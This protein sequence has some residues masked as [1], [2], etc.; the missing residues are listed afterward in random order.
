MSILFNSNIEIESVDLK[1]LVEKLVKLEQKINDHEK[2]LQEMSRL[3]F[4][5]NEHLAL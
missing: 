3:L 4:I 1:S 5:V 2:E